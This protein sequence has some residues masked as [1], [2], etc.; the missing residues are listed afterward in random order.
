LNDSSHAAWIKVEQLLKFLHS[1]NITEDKKILIKDENINRIKKIKLECKELNITTFTFHHM[2]KKT[3]VYLNRLPCI[4]MDKII[5][6]SINKIN[7]HS[8][9]TISYELA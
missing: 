6:K 9:V 1:K 2:I 5:I 7:N 3:A 8:L 4:T